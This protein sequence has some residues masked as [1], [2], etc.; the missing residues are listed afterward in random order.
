MKKVCLGLLRVGD[1]IAVVMCCFCFLGERTSFTFTLVT[2]V[3]CGKTGRFLRE[4]HLIILLPR[5][6]NKF[7]KS[8]ILAKI[9]NSKMPLI[10]TSELKDSGRKGTFARCLGNTRWLIFADVHLH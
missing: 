8:D 3:S 1:G 2:R 7:G 10:A 5:V 4:L 6:I 9:R